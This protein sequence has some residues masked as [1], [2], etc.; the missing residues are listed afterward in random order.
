MPKNKHIGN[1]QY[2]LF[3]LT[4]INKNI[5]YALV[6]KCIQFFTSRYA[7]FINAY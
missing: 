3:R 5:E 1:L 2:N 7:I 4:K 6:Y